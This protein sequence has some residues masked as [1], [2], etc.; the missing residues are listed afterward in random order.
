MDK[1][2]IN[3]Q[4]MA[5]NFMRISFQET[6]QYL[7]IISQ[8]LK[9]QNNQDFVQQLI[10]GMI[11]FI[12]QKSNNNIDI[13]SLHLADPKLIS[14]KADIQKI[15][16]NL[17][18]AIYVPF[19]NSR[20]YVIL[21]IVTDQCKVFSTKCRS[22]F[23]ICLEVYRPEEEI[24]TIPNPFKL[25]RI[26]LPRTVGKTEKVSIERLSTTETT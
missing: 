2:P 18:A 7:I 22:P 9:Q 6:N 16:R 11:S 5:H 21:N 19:Y 8:F 4:N 10:F 26:S 3:W 24:E 17:P 25:D 1:I 23:Y 12:F 13:F 14:L 15:N 20:N